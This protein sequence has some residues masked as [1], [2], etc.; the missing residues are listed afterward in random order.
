ME[1]YKYRSWGNDF[2][3]RVLTSQ[4]IF[5]STPSEFNDPFDCSCFINY[6]LL[7]SKDI[8]KD[9]NRHFSNKGFN[10][11][12]RRDRFRH[13]RKAQ[14]EEA[15]QNLPEANVKAINETYGIFSLSAK[16]DNILMW[17]HYS[18]FHKGICIG[19]DSNYLENIEPVNLP[20]SELHLCKVKY[21]DKYPEL[22]P[23]D[24]YYL[25]KMMT[26]KAAD[27]SYEEEYRLVYFKGANQISKLP[28]EAFTKI[29]LGCKFP[30]NQVESVKTILAS[31]RIRADVYKCFVSKSKYCLDLSKI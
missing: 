10:R 11:K 30:D 14:I 13:H 18:D 12:E 19:F 7:T 21:S 8:Q 3:K 23:K 2:H 25:H 16:N 15:R 4:E 24:P 6:S 29:I 5:F 31:N 28:R 27:W 20:G 22:N 26:T 17:A 9:L 1:L